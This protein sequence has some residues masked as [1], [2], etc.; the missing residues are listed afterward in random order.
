MI[1][2]HP[3]RELLVAY[4][5]GQLTGEEAE[6]VKSLI[7]RDSGARDFLN[8][9]H[10]SEL[11]FKEAFE[12]LLHLKAPDSIVDL[13][14]ETALQTERHPILSRFTIISAVAGLVLGIVI[15]S[16]LP[17]FINTGRQ[18]PELASQVSQYQSL[19]QR[20][21]VENAAQADHQQLRELFISQL[22]VDFVVPELTGLEFKRG[23]LLALHGEPLVQL[24]Y[25]GQTGVPVA[26]CILPAKKTGGVSPL[27]GSSHGMRYGYWKDS[28]LEFVLVGG[29]RY[30]Y[31]ELVKEIREQITI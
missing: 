10:R 22:G 3:E 20:A 2:D 16:L 25:L 19:Y 1:E 7:D 14:H 28:G 31:R 17:D 24:V 6:W 29:D 27:F 15:S 23:Q 21:T 5:D 13:I 12:P 9:L 18:V 8:Q 4:A 11:P 26:L 30:A